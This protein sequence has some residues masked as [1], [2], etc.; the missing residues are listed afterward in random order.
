LPRY[1]KIIPFFALAGA[2]AACG[3]DK[4]QDSFLSNI[5]LS[6]KA[7][8]EFA[9]VPHK[10]LELP[11]NL[12][13]LPAPIPGARNRTDLTPIEDARVALGGNPNG[14]VTVQSDAAVLAAT[15]AR[16][17]PTGI[18]QVLAEEDV[19]YRRY[20][21][22]APLVRWFNKNTDAVVYEDMLLDPTI[23]TLRQRAGGRR[24]PAIPPPSFE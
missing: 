12:A 1:L 21:K 17:A 8:V 3:D 20:H 18:R 7:P 14:G 22:G 11:E 13:E 15:G 10:P 24:T 6:S 19:E 5:G 16:T 2:L 9:V 23:E 4:E